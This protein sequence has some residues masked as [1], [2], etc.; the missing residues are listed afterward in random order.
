MQLQEWY[1]DDIQDYDEQELKATIKE[2]HDALQKTEAFTRVR[3]SD[4]TPRQLKDVIQAKCFVRSRPG[5][6][7][8]KLK[9]R[10]VAESYTQKVNL[11]EIYAATPA[12]IYNESTCPTS[13]Q[14][15]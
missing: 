2:K 7:Q 4:Y 3:R 6:K 14:R 13:N 12:A 9:A 8:R 11:D 1:D 15:Y 5:G 10:F